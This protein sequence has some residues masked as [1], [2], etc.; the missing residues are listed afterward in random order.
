MGSYSLL[1]LN[2]T[3]QAFETTYNDR[4]IPIDQLKNVGDAYAI[5]IVDTANKLAH[6]SRSPTDAAPRIDAAEKVIAAQWQAYKATQLT[7]REAELVRQADAAMKVADKGKEELKN[8]LTQADQT[9]FQTF[10]PRPALSRGRA[11]DADY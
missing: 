9:A 7:P 4:V 5:D 8:L 2:E 1:T 11:T 10:C 3:N 6:G